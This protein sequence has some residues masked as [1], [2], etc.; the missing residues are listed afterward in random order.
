MIY[1]VLFIM[2]TSSIPTWTSSSA[3]P[4]K[5][6][7]QLFWLSASKKCEPQDWRTRLQSM[8]QQ[9]KSRNQWSWEWHLSLTLFGLMD[10]TS[11]CRL[12]G[13]SQHTVSTRPVMHFLISTKVSESV[14]QH[15]LHNHSVTYDILIM[16]GW[17]YLKMSL[18][19]LNDCFRPP[20]K[21]VSSKLT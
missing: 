7:I 11:V 20:W 16:S 17:N 5:N 15:L 12:A 9:R 6:K 2:T 14:T 1:H 8:P 3:L 18:K 10:R 19:M 21:T 13:F 4:E